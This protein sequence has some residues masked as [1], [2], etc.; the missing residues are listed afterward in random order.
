MKA[1]T[2]FAQP[3]GKIDDFAFDEATVEVFDDMVSRSVPFYA[4]TQRIITEIA[5]AHIGPRGTIYDLGCSTGTTLLS[6]AKR[7]DSLEVRLIGID[8]SQPMLERAQQ[9]FA[10][11]GLSSMAKWERRDVNAPMEF[12]P[13]DAVIM[14]LTLQFV[15]P[16]YRQDLIDSIY[17]SLKPG[18]CFILL[19]KILSD[20][21][22]FNRL[23]IDIYHAFK[24]GNG[25]SNLEISQKREA[26]EN[27]LVP[28]RLSENLELMKR[29]GFTEIDTFFRCYNFAGFVAVKRCS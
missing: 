27:V 12:D 1:D 20:S 6:L 10:E 26:L 3:R 4:E 18:G 19:E 11:A 21:P 28:Y 9:K 24:R 14:N 25:Y 16:L 17:R 23:Y 8:L 13:A 29:G 5:A 2:L 22:Y 7:L 15:R